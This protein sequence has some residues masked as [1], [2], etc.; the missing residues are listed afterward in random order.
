M[1]S[2]VF[3]IVVDNPAHRVQLN[4]YLANTHHHLVYA[5]DGEDGFDRFAEVKPDIVL[6]YAHVSRLDGTILCQL[7]RQQPNGEQTPIVMM[8]DEASNRSEDW[9]TSVGA[10]AMLRLPFDRAALLTCIAPL[11]ATGRPPPP[12]R[13]SSPPPVP[14]ADIDN[15][16][17]TEILGATATLDF[18][19][20][21][22]ERESSK[23]G[24]ERSEPDLDTVVSFQNPFY[25]GD[26]A[27]VDPTIGDSEESTP[28]R[29]AG[30]KLL[31]PDEPLEPPTAAERAVTPIAE[32]SPPE[33]VQIVRGAAM[34]PPPAP[35]LDPLEEPPITSSA[36]APD[37]TKSKLIEEMPLE[38]GTPSS[39]AG[40]R[41]SAIRQ[42]AQG[43]ERRG[44][45][46]SQLGKR[47]TKRVR[48]MFD[49][50]DEVDY[51]QL[52]GVEQDATLDALQTAY[53]DLSLE[54]HPD[55]FFLLRSGD[56]KE[57]IYFIYRRVFEAYRVLADPNRRAAYDE[58]IAGKVEKRAPE[59]MRE[60]SSPATD[61]AKPA[62]D[63]DVDAESPRASALLDKAK[64]AYAVGDFNA[65]RLYL[66]FA[67][68][69][70][71]DNAMIVEAL[72][73]VTGQIAPLL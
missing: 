21:T 55:R 31:S 12:E 2:S 20:Q 50:L 45:D 64:A 18:P 22:E 69:Y 33:G 9:A 28:G 42:R 65:T 63:L 5:T 36:S 13:P 39:P 73:R 32:R 15:M 43:K 71:K 27:I 61:V 1:A 56:L 62:D 24:K 30:V 14:R 11:L 66:S 44:L 70:E 57:K 29:G 10:D 34:T 72:D 19:E 25:E 6:I 49:L 46:A 3:L 8:A 37:S 58:M 40:Q 67:R 51:Y 17:P 52:L 16:D 59:Q 54:F 47:L 4:R 60:E 41:I 68:A 38:G 53:F 48:K 26:A 23:P 35:P 7:I